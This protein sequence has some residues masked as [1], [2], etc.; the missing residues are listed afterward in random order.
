MTISWILS[1]KIRS[2]VITLLAVLVL[3]SCTAEEIIDAANNINLD[4]ANNNINLLNNETNETTAMYS[5]SANLSNAQPLSGAVLAQTTV[6]IFFTN[7]T[8]YSSMTFYC[9]KGISGASTGESHNAAVSDSSA[10]FIYTVNLNQF[11]TTGTRELYVDAFKVDGS[12]R[13][14]FSIN[15]SIN[16]GQN[17]VPATSKVSLSWV[18]PSEREDNNAISP[19]EIAGYKIYYGNTQGNYTNSIS[20]NDGDTYSHTIN[21]LTSGTYYIVITTRDIEGRESKYSSVVTRTI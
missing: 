4:A 14:N 10:P 12:P 1:T 2:T 17:S 5:Y 11:T 18:A 13:S 7:T 15:F 19:Y 20:I 6:Y 21:N 16:I 9:C 8:E 3:S